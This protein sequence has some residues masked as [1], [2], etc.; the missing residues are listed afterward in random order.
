MAR[1][2]QSL[3][4]AVRRV[5]GED[6]LTDL[7]ALVLETHLGFANKLLHAAGLPPA[8]EIQAVPQMPTASGR[9]VDLEVLARS[10]GSVVARLWSENKV[11]ARYQREQLPDYARDLAAFPKPHQ[12]ITVV[13]KPSEVPVDELYP[14]VPRWRGFTWR[15][16][17]LM[18]WEAGDEVSPDEE[19]LPW[20]EVALRPESPARQRLLFELLTYL[21]EEHGVVLDPLGH[22]HVAALAYIADTGDILEE[23]LR[24]VGEFAH[25]DTDADIKWQRTVTSSGRP[26]TRT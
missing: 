10:R 25:V 20:D 7:L 19:R 21:E 22:A 18:A 6:R 2:P 15:D 4:E 14:A 12:L 3:F 9:C 17:A 8:E 13:D 24:R 16:I 5:K 1:A 23:L 11:G 26:S